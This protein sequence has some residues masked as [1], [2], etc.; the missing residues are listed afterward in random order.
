MIAYN[1]PRQLSKPM[2]MLLTETMYLTVYFAVLINQQQT[3][4]F[5]DFLMC[6]VSL[7]QL[8]SIPVKYFIATE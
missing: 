5:L 3:R 6:P 1:N 4:D 7:A 8:E 2:L